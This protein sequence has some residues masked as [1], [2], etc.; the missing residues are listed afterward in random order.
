MTGGR[1]RGGYCGLL[2][3][4]LLLAACGLTGAA[5]GRSAPGLSYPL[6]GLNTEADLRA[7]AMS[8]GCWLAGLPGFPT[9]N[10]RNVHAGLD[11]RA[12]LGEVV[13]AVAP[14]IVEPTSD[15]PHSGYGPGWTSGQVMIVRTTG[16][17]GGSYLALYGHTQNHLVKGGEAVV[18]GQPLA[19]VGP[20]LPDDGG[21]HLHLTVRL[22]ELPRWGWGT[23]TAAGQTPRD[24]AET[25]GTALEVVRLGYRDPRRWLQG[26]VDRE[27]LVGVEG[28]RRLDA[29]VA[30]YIQGFH[31]DPDGGPGSVTNALGLPAAT[32]GGAPGTARRVGKG[33]LQTFVAPGGEESGLLLGDRAEQAI[34]VH[35]P[36]WKVYQARGG[37][38]G[39]GYPMAEE[40]RKNGTVFQQFAGGV[41]TWAEDQGSLII[42]L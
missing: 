2:A 31:D 14:G 1:G 11:L 25:A 26:E 10:G 38:V 39:F 8:G 18:A 24:G 36:L 20:W 3:G 4:M 6:D 41:I 16:P 5:P 42:P 12:S 29:F 22:G 9:Y 35:G 13:Y 7:R 17:G 32:N 30:R 23:P 34:W 15:V 28:K 21:P 19:E 40:Q 37:P 27:L 33:W